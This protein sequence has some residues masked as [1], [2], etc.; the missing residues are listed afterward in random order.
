MERRDPQVLHGTVTLPIAQSLDR[1]AVLRSTL[2]RR[3]IRQQPRGPG[4][5]IVSPRDLIHQ[6]AATFALAQTGKYIRV[7]LTAETAVLGLGMSVEQRGIP[8]Q[9]TDSA[10]AAGDMEIGYPSEEARAGNV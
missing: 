5:K 10:A 8:G 1:A 4:H 7:D 3:L 9:I 2:A 6:P